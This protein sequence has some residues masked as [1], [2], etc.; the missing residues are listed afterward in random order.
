M[1]EFVRSV[2]EGLTPVDVIREIILALIISGLALLFTKGRPLVKNFIAWRSARKARTRI[3]E[4]REQLDNI[5][6]AETD[7]DW[8]WR[9]TGKRTIVGL[10]GIGAMI[11]GS[12]ML[13][14]GFQLDFFQ[15]P[16]DMDF[17]TFTLYMVVMFCGGMLAAFF[18]LL[19]AYRFLNRERT[20]A[21]L[22]RHI[23]EF[24]TR[25]KRLERR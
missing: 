22:L 1:S 9:H 24:E 5:T 10:I 18:S 2:I 14:L 23:E 7:P 17:L 21:S 20:K 12:T 8:G 13:H 4:L 11:F 25:L 6:H 15:K 16:Y 19:D 3:K